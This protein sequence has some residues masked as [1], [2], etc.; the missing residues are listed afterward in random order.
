MCHSEDDD[1]WQG[2]SCLHLP[3]PAFRAS[4]AL[5]SS[6]GRMILLADSDRYIVAFVGDS[7]E[8]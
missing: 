8:D 6:C 7:T 1:V 3:I 5:W 4:S 2:A